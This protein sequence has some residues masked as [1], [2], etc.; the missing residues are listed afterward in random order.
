[1]GAISYPRQNGLAVVL[2]EL[3]RI[4][5]TLFILDRN[6]LACRESVFLHLKRW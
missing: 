6:V 1:M 4:E 2:R 3:G 5:R